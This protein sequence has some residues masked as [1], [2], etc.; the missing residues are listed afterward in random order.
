MSRASPD[1]RPP[2]RI[3]LEEKGHRVPPG[4]WQ[5]PQERQRDR[6][7]LEHFKFFCSLLATPPA[8]HKNS[9]SSSPCGGFHARFVAGATATIPQGVKME[10]SGFHPVFRTRPYP[11]AWLGPRCADGTLGEEERCIGGCLHHGHVPVATLFRIPLR[12]SGSR[13]KLMVHRLQTGGP[14]PSASG[15]GGFVLFLFRPL[16]LAHGFIAVSSEESAAGC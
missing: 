7:T 11:P 2:I 1:R 9:K 15:P 14:L 6:V 16:G 4:R 13:L 5:Q 12:L 8:D 3:L 10:K